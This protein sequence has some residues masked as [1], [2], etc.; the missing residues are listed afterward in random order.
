[1]I[2]YKGQSS[3]SRSDEERIDP[4]AQSEDMPTPVPSS[5]PHAAAAFAAS[6][7]RFV[8]SG[9]KTVDGPLHEL[10]MGHCRACEFLRGSQCSLCRCLVAK[11]AW[12]PHEDCPVGRW[13]SYPRAEQGGK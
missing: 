12:L 10:R 13:E 9:F 5:L 7:A 1:M 4:A 3:I 11:K 6:L 8:A 2:Q